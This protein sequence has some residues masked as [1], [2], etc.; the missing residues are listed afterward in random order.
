MCILS[1]KSSLFFF[2]ETEYEVIFFLIIWVKVID[3]YKLIGGELSPYTAKVR[4]YL[5]YKNI[6]F[7]PVQASAEVSLSF[8]LFFFFSS[9]KRETVKTAKVIKDSNLAS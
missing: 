5:R 7:E 4:C 6:P 2:N 1:Q 3:M 9:A 8:F